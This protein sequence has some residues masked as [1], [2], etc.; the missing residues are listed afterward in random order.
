MLKIVHISTTPKGG[1]GIAAYRLHK[2]LLDSKTCH[3]IF[4]CK[5]GNYSP[6]LENI[7]TVP[8]IKKS[9]IER[10][11]RKIF[12]IKTPEALFQQ[13]KGLLQGK[14]EIISSPFS[15]YRI[16]NHKD[17][18]DADIIHLH[19]I[20][21]F[22]NY[23]S[24]FKKLSHKKIVWT[25]HDMNPFMGIFH[26][27]GDQLRNPSF[28]K[29]NKEI[30]NLK[31][32]YLQPTKIHI[33]ALSNWM[34]EEAKKVKQ[35]ANSHF[36]LIPNGVD[37]NQFYPLEEGDCSEKKSILFVSESLNNYRK[38]IDLF[39]DCLSH[40]NSP[41]KV[42][43]VGNGNITLSH[44]NNIEYIN[45][46]AVYDTEKLNAIF[47]KADIFILPSREDNLPNV[48]LESFASGTPVVSFSNGGMREWINDDTG[49]LCN[50]ISSTALAEGINFALKNFN[51]SKNS[52]IRDF[53]TEHFSMQV[54]SKN[55]YEFYCRVVT[56]QGF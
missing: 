3:S 10:A 20:T 50:E 19:W 56:G 13:K 16:E 7:K 9:L 21:H 33:I 32:K 54:Q 40:I 18:Q 38:G 55:I 45:Y 51:K 12:N 42:L 2:A 25:F 43:S 22:L 34:K 14:Y 39:L 15:D 28:E 53:A 5:E 1:A 41:I 4:I 26:Y 49:Y 47:A 31:L 30:F 29:L 46:G 23:P 6:T 17:V 8:K 11:F 36:E 24:F 52:K 35:F 27:K 44:T 37:I 48:M